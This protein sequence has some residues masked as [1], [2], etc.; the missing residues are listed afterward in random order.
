MHALVAFLNNPV[1]RVLRVVVGIALFYIGVFPMRDEPAGV[2][3]AI[4]GFEP[5][6][7]GFLGRSALELVVRNRRVV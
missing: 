5:I 4:I 1:G 3:I 6:I 2:V 7:L